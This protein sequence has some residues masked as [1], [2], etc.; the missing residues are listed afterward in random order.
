MEE[1][2]RLFVEIQNHRTK[3]THLYTIF[4]IKHENKRNKNDGTN[5]YIYHWYISNVN[6]FRL[7]N[8]NS[9]WFFSLSYGGFF[10]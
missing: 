2:T 1:S 6:N 10:P 4:F 5:V 7:E 9:K 3:L 8:S